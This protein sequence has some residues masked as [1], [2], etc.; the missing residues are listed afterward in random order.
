MI[1]LSEE[2]YAELRKGLESEAGIVTALKRLGVWKRPD[3]QK[4]HLKM[5]SYFTFTLPGI[6]DAEI[7]LPVTLLDVIENMTFRLRNKDEYSFKFG[8][9]GLLCMR[10]AGDTLSQV[11]LNKQHQRLRRVKEGKSFRYE[12]C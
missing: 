3:V 8:Q 2:F 4:E 10:P 7:S 12:L 11:V 6:R 9:N 5:I 1:K